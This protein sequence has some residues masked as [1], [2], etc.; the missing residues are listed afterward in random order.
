MKIPQ[1]TYYINNGLPINEFKL[2][3]K[4]QLIYHPGSK[5][6][7]LKWFQ[8]GQEYSPR[9][10]IGYQ[11]MSI[12]PTTETDEID[13]DILTSSNFHGRAY[14]ISPE[15]CSVT[16]S[17]FYFQSFEDEIEKRTSFFLEFKTHVVI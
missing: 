1:N 3:Y 17:L 11:Y 9:R 4:T 6:T 14:Y 7:I 15:S 8:F 10:C 2:Y 16:N 13:G 12:S 5:H